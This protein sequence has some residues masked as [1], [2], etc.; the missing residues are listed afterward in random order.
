MDSE[1]K[2]EMI[3]LEVDK[4]R[5]ER[6]LQFLADKSRDQF[7]RQ[8]DEF[9]ETLNGLNASSGVRREDRAKVIREDRK[10][11]QDR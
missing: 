10:V 4:Q 2:V 7:L 11:F 6:H 3:L 1:G 9:E 5:Y 8:P